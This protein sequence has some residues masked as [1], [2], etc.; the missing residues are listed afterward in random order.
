MS[1]YAIPTASNFVNT[2]VS[3]L[4]AQSS[5]WSDL[6]I[7]LPNRRASTMLRDAFLRQS[8]GVPQILPRMSVLGEEDESL[9]LLTLSDTPIPA[10]IDPQRRSLL[11]AKFIAIL[12]DDRPMEQCLALA[13]ALGRLIDQTHMEQVDATQLGQLV[14]DGK[15]AEHWHITSSFLTQVMAEHWPSVLAEENKID[16]G[17][18]RH[19]AVQQLTQLIAD[20]RI[21]GHVMI[22]GSMAP[23]PALRELLSRAATSDQCSVIL[24]GLDRVMQADE[25]DEVIEGHPQFLMK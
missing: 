10:P 21:D 8:D 20:N 7:F 12:H 3:G 4:N 6:R 13:D 1:V 19:L 16:P 11:L 25:W 2:L 9:S 23:F 17:L 22:A 24:P 15:L 5:A 14:D 18:Y